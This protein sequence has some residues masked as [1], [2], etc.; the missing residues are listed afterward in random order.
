V[1]R[2][3]V[4]KL[5]LNHKGKAI[6]VLF[7]NN[8]LLYRA[9]SELYVRDVAIRLKRRGHHPVAYS[10][11]LGPVAED[12][13]AAGVPTIDDL[14]LLR[15]EPDVIHGHHHFDAAA[16]ALRFP[17]AP[18]V[19]ACHGWLPWQ[20]SPLILASIRRYVA[21]SDL[22][23][24]YLLTSGVSP[25][26]IAVIPN[27]VDLERFATC[28]DPAPI[29][30]RAVA[31]GNPWWKEAPALAAVRSACE[32]KGIEFEAFG[33]GLGNSIERPESVLPSF[34][35]VFAVGRSALEAM[36]C[37]CA[38]VLA[39]PIGFGGLVTNETFAR[40]RA[41]NFGH[42]ALVG[43]A[44]TAETVAA[45][46]ERYDAHDVA[47]VAQRV[48]A[49]A[50]IET[51]ID[52]WE[53]QYAL[54][55]AE[56]PAPLEQVIADASTYLVKLKALTYHF[57]QDWHQVKHEANL[58]S[59][60]LQSERAAFAAERVLNEAK[61]AEEQKLFEAKRAQEQRLQT[62]RVELEARCAALS[63]EAEGLRFALKS[64]RGE[65]DWVRAKPRGLKR[66]LKK[67]RKICALRLR[68]Y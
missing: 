19:H 61:R 56:G 68:P 64:V 11:A 28:R 12:L 2:M 5:P 43:R 13:R 58:S 36:A 62:Q 57:E 27:F 65:L 20:E 45:A 67:I 53:A 54:S 55:I 40:L 46:L 29:V 49:E 37:G 25:E 50:G 7:S 39:D 23:R 15:E 47:R 63:S 30:R 51:A 10:T 6:R 4:L 17:G 1:I 33:H 8:T 18:A 42:G 66:V 41:A 52:Q 21:I 3:R 60:A 32:N 34:D 31:Y 38:V 35:V 9:G 16:A 22:T 26:R 24:E 44:T 14:R 59:A 48:R